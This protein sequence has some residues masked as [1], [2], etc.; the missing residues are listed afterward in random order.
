[1]HELFI[2]ICLVSF[3]SK[4]PAC[5]ACFRPVLVCLLCFPPPSFQKSNNDVFN[6]S[7]PAA[8]ATGAPTVVAA[9]PS[10]PAATAAVAIAAALSKSLEDVAGGPE[11]HHRSSMDHLPT[12]KKSSL[13]PTLEAGK[14]RLSFKLMRQVKVSV[15]LCRTYTLFSYHFACCKV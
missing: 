14:N 9:C 7:L 8:A 1:M 3:V 10:K 5:R 2:V 15:C 4:A 13:S 12:H 11:R 6:F